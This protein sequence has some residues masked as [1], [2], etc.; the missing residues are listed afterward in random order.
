MIKW[1]LVAIK[2][3]WQNSG[4]IFECSFWQNW[5]ILVHCFKF[6]ISLIYWFH[7]RIWYMLGSTY[8][9]WSAGGQAKMCWFWSK[10]FF[11]EWQPFSLWWCKTHLIVDI[12]LEASSSWK[13]C[14]LMVPWLFLTIW[15]SFPFNW[16]WQFGSIC[17]TC[18]L[19]KQTLFMMP[20]E[21]LPAMV[22][23][24]HE[25]TYWNFINLSVCK[26]DPMLSLQRS[27]IN[28]NLCTSFFFLFLLP[29][30]TSVKNLYS[31]VCSFSPENKQFR[32]HF[33]GIHI[34]DVLN[35]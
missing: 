28:E 23:P 30:K 21:K 3:F 5:Q 8:A 31:L 25:Q 12:V 35:S 11:L 14:A 32:C 22:N 4:W 26:F 33:Y 2:N 27:K 1:F 10:S 17:Y 24:D 16:G 29:L 15:I 19:A 18:I 13:V 6:N 20:T 34:H 9:W 7:N